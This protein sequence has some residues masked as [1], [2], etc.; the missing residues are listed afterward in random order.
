M[1]NNTTWE[2]PA[3]EQFVSDWNGS[4][5]TALSKLNEAFDAAGQDCIVR[6]QGLAQYLGSR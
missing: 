1:I 6:S 5:K 3:R 4:F 2:G